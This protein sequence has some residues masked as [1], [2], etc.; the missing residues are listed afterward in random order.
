[1]TFGSPEV[2]SVLSSHNVITFR[3]LLHQKDSFLHV[4]IKK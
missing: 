2:L 1:M 4:N 3:D